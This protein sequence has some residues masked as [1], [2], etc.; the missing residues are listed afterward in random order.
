LYHFKPSSYRTYLYPLPPLLCNSSLPQQ[1]NLIILMAPR[2][3]TPVLSQLPKT[4]VQDLQRLHSRVERRRRKPQNKRPPEYYQNL[5][6]EQDKVKAVIQNDYSDAN[7]DN[8]SIIR[9]KFVR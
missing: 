7:K 1:S 2:H 8:V 5:I 9:G 6:K 4:S 3:C